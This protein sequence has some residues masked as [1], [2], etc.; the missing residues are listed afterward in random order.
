MRGCL[1]TVAALIICAGPY[2]ESTAGLQQFPAERSAH[3]HCKKG[4]YV[5][6]EAAEA[7]A[8]ATRNE[9]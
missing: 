8:R 5:C 4:P 7:G 6:E 1:F 3:A 9:E 2:A